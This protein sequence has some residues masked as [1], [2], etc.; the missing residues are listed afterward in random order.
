MSVGRSGCS[1]RASGAP[2]CGGEGREGLRRVAA[3]LRPLSSGANLSGGLCREEGKAPSLTIRSPSTAVVAAA[4]GYLM[5]N[6]SISHALMGP[7]LPLR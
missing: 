1:E 4:G 3:A 7:S 6:L 5:T 2:G